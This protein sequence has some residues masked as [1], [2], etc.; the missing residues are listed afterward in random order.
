MAP[1]GTPAAPADEGGL[2]GAGPPMS[3]LPGRSIPQPILQHIK[4]LSSNKFEG[5]APGTRGE[6]LTVAYL[7]TQFHDLG[8][9]PGNP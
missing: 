4:V 8:L 5:R 9:Q 6:D 1:A 2:A 7:E 3:A